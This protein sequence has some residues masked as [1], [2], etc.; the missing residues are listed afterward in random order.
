MN[1][2]IALCLLV[3]MRSYVFAQTPDSTSQNRTDSSLQLRSD[4]ALQTVADSNSQAFSKKDK[5][6]ISQSQEVYKLKA[7]S[8][9]PITAIGTGWSLYAFTQ[10]YSK[11]KST[12]EKILSLDKNDIPSFDRHGADVFH[13][14]A[15]EVANSLFYGSMP[16]PLIL[17]L[18]K[19]IR[20]DGLK[21]AILYLE[22]MAVTGLLY[23]G[24]TYLTDRYRPYAYN[25]D[26]PMSKRTRGGAKN[27]F[28]AGHVALVG[29][30]TFFIAKVL[31]D[32][33]PDSK[34]RWLPFTLAG[35]ATGSTAYLRYRGGEHF[36]S[37]II[38]GTIVG[39]L[40]GILVPHVHKNKDIADR[41]LSFT[42]SYTGNTPQFGIVY[43]LNP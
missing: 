43:K 13:P 28:F 31:N 20:K 3:A 24:S 7:A 12:E 39:T 22:S 41:R 42:T 23:T 17:M 10:I 25:P 34:A 9:I 35:L 36:L 19:E 16:L 32:Y 30:S 26:V 4:T 29:T 6:N 40:T 38:L 37:D 18:D 14:K 15:S 2:I 27:S 21:I 5:K 1:K 33:H 11:D 8:D